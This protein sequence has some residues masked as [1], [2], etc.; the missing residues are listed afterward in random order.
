MD[1]ISKVT[2]GECKIAAVRD[3]CICRLFSD[4][5]I[6]AT[7]GGRLNVFHSSFLCLY[8]TSDVRSSR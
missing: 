7:D 2:T 5:R 6:R 4:N 1:S 8:I 3:E